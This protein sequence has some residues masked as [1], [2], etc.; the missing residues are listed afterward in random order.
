MVL[1]TQGFVDTP[2]EFAMLR[3]VMQVLG[4]DL[5][6]GYRWTLLEPVGFASMN[7]LSHS[8]RT[9]GILAFVRRT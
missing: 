3:L 9:F 4:N 8:A 1:D 6:V 2:M 7:T 5:L